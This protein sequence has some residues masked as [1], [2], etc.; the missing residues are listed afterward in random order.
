[1]IGTS[2]SRLSGEVDAE[3]IDHFEPLKQ[4][5]RERFAGKGW[6]GAKTVVDFVSSDE[7]DCH[8]S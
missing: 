8:R 3:G 2:S 7:T 1:M 4:A 5:L 6:V